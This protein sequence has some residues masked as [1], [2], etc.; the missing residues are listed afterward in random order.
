MTNLLQMSILLPTQLPDLPNSA[1]TAPC[2][3]TSSRPEVT[4]SDCVVIG[5]LSI[6]GRDCFLQI[7]EILIQSRKTLIRKTYSSKLKSPSIWPAQH[8]LGLVQASILKILDY[9]IAL[10]QASLSFSSVK[11]H[12]T[13]FL[14]CLAPELGFFGSFLTGHY[15]SFLEGYYILTN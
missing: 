10:K 11:V 8:S 2:P 1:L 4:A 7:Q 5:W 15:Q 3:D 9:P 12:L 6:T 14:T 13:A